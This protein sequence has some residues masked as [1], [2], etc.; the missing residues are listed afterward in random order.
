MEAYAAGFGIRGEKQLQAK[1][2]VYFG[3]IEHER[4]YKGNDPEVISG[5]H[6]SG[7]L[8]AG[9]NMHVHV[10]VSRK[11]GSNKIKLSPMATEKGDTDNAMLN[12]KAVQRGFN[13]TAFSEKVEREFDQHFGYKRSLNQSIAY[14][15]TMKHGTISEKAAIRKKEIAQAYQNKNERDIP[16]NKSLTNT[17]SGQSVINR[18]EEKNK[19]I[20][21]RSV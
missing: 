14:L 7:E 13:R 9:N 12:A 21:G 20:G 1:D 15:T 16:K 18:P 4:R 8:K 3:K 5:Q 11:D 17:I 10:L 6:Q 2:L 19:S